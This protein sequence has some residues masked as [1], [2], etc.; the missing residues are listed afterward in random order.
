MSDQAVRQSDFEWTVKL[1]ETI[2]NGHTAAVI[3]RIPGRVEFQVLEAVEEATGERFQGDYIYTGPGFNDDGVESTY[4]WFYLKFDHRGR[5]NIKFRMSWRKG[6]HLYGAVETFE[7]KSGDR[8]PPPDYSSAE[9]ELLSE[10][11]NW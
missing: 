5:H 2:K 11:F 6:S 7:I 8:Y 10:L 1:P 3:G 9:R 4:M